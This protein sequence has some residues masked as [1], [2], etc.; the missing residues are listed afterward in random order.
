MV[1]C[2]CGAVATVG[3]TD[4]SGYDITERADDGGRRQRSDA[5]GQRRSDQVDSEAGGQLVN[6]AFAGS[7]IKIPVA[8]MDMNMDLFLG[9]GYEEG[10]M[11]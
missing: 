1:P 8:Q 9:Q 6:F 10:F 2:R 3:S 4:H 11:R 7:F 5:F